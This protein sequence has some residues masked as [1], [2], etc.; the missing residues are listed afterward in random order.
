MNT[1][2]KKGSA[3]A[4]PFFTRG[5]TYGEKDYDDCDYDDPEPEVAGPRVAGIARIAGVAGVAEGSSSVVAASH[6]SNLLSV[7]ILCVFY[8]LVKGDDRVR[9]E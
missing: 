5:L 2:N 8:P 3:S 7:C 4:L 9:F 6:I 1:D